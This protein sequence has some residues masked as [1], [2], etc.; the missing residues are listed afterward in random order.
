MI[1]KLQRTSQAFNLAF[2]PVSL[3]IA[4]LKNRGDLT[5][6][7]MITAQYVILQKYFSHP[8]LVIYFFRTPPMELKLGLQIGGRQLIAIHLDRSN[9]LANQ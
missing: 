1:I 6:G 7:L 4:I 5:L 2:F 9:Y 3:E 8:S